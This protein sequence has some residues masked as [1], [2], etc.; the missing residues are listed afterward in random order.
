M[1]IDE[2]TDDEIAAW[3]DEA[4]RDVIAARSRSLATTGTGWPT[5]DAVE[6]LTEAFAISALGGELPKNVHP[7]AREALQRGPVGPLTLARGIARAV[8]RPLARGGT[9][10]EI[11]AMANTLPAFPLALE[12]AARRLLLER[13]SEVLAD[14]VLPVT[15]SHQVANYH[16]V[17]LGVTDIASEMP[18]PAGSS[19]QY[20]RAVV[21][22][23]AV[24]TAA[25]ASTPSKLIVGEQTLRNDDINFVPAALAAFA[26]ACARAEARRIA[27]LLEANELPSGSPIFDAANSN[28]GVGALDAAGLGVGLATL[29]KQPSE[30]GQATGL[31]CAAII[32]HPDDEATVLALIEAL[33]V[34]RQP[35][36]V[37]SPFLTDNAS[38]YFVANPTQAPCLARLTMI[39]APPSGI[40][41][42]A[43]AS[44][45][46]RDANGTERSAP[47]IALDLVHSAAIEAVSPVG[48][49]KLT[50]T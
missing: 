40:S 44:A 23:L 24:E 43:S 20:W 17:T 22:K 45:S 50:K 48:L 49:V 42:G 37:A 41:V 36:L 13:P 46:W 12:N 29:R 25:I 3:L 15:F 28:T 21:P 16:G 1:N 26:S 38:W 47:G 33:P 5:S 10:A 11:S 4:R 39:G 9:S 8:G 19:G 7:L 34:A 35:L 32:V 18:G 31:A 6:G 30:A 2:L 27:E 14:A